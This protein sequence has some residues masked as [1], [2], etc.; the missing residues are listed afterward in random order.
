M[1]N[2]IIDEV[3]AVEEEW[4]LA[5]GKGILSTPIEQMIHPFY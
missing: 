2:L 1:Q 3:D 4:L 5:S